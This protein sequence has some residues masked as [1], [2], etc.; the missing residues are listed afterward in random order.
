MCK[1]CDSTLQEADIAEDILVDE[2]T[3]ECVRSFCYLE[4]TLGTDCGTDLSAT[5]IIING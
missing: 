1:R 4:E 5:A 3:C 2:K